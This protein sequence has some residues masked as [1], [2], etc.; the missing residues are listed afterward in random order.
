MDESVTP[1]VALERA[2]HE[3]VVEGFVINWWFSIWIWFFS[4]ELQLFRFLSRLLERVCF[5]GRCSA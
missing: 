3:R 4:L 2:L 5:S 1:A